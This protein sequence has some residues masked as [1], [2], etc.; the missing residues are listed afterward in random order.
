V[1]EP[2]EHEWLT[3]EDIKN[4]LRVNEETVRRW[5]RTNELP[6]LDLGGPRVGYRVHRDD[7][8]RFIERR[9]GTLSSLKNAKSDAA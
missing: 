5:I 7:L 1:E 8:A 3:V 9:R 2:H 4:M 6:V